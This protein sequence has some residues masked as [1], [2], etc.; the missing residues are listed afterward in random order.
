MT[1]EPLSTTNRTRHLSRVVHGCEVPTRALRPFPRCSSVLISLRVNTMPVRCRPPVKHCCP[2]GSQ[3]RSSD[4]AGDQRCCGAWPPALVVDTTSSPVSLTFT[5]AAEVAIP[6]A[7]VTG[8]AMRRAAD[9]YGGCGQLVVGKWFIG[10]RRRSGTLSGVPAA[11]RSPSWLPTTSFAAM[12]RIASGGQ[13]AHPDGGVVSGLEVKWTGRRHG[14]RADRRW[15]T[16][17]SLERISNR[18]RVD[19]PDH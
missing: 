10:Q 3:R 6:V 4:P 2:C 1:L 11:R 9:L 7:Y 17:W 13:I 16:S 5:V 15:A 12:W 18:L 19:F 14:R 8:L